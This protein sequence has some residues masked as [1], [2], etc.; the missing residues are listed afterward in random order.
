MLHSPICHPSQE[1]LPLWSKRDRKYLCNI[2]TDSISCSRAFTTRHENIKIC[3]SSFCFFR[4]RKL[5][6]RELS[7]SSSTRLAVWISLHEFQHRWMPRWCF[8]HLS[9][10]WLISQLHYADACF[11]S[12][13]QHPSLC[14][15]GLSASLRLRVQLR[16]DSLISHLTVLFLSCRVIIPEV[17]GQVRNGLYLKEATD[18]LVWKNRLHFLFAELSLWHDGK[19]LQWCKW[20]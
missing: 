9:N 17:D 14:A 11:R 7:F 18:E 15:N 8:F 5:L 2:C 19:V 3:N 1:G 20:L 6:K 16:G 12:S 13:T 4:L 10:F